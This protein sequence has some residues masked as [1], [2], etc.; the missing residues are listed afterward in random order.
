MGESDRWPLVDVISPAFI[1]AVRSF[2]WFE[3]LISIQMDYFPHYT[4]YCC[5]HPEAVELC[6]R[7]MEKDSFAKFNK[8][9][10]ARPECK[11][12]NLES[13]LI[14]PVQRICKYPLL[15]RELIRSCGTDHDD[16]AQLQLV[17][18]KMEVAICTLIK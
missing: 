15:I 11:G 2:S 13:F 9:C 18:E 14:K 8:E 16:Y 10:S 1:A 5:N 3:E 4:E 7:K 6:K 17:M 12:L